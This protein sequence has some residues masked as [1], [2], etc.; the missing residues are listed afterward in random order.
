MDTQHLKSAN[1]LLHVAV[2]SSMQNINKKI[3][4]LI[5]SIFFFAY[6]DARRLSGSI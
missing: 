1:K 2:L 6:L 4:P 5:Y 3:I